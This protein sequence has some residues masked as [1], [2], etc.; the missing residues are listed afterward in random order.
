MGGGGRRPV[1]L[2][3]E[4][5]NEVDKFAGVEGREDFVLAAVQ[6][7]LRRRR[8]AEAIDQAAGSLKDIDIPGWETPESTVEWVRTQR[9][10]DRDHWA[11]AE[12]DANKG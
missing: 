4:I 9:R 5:V 7:Q 2:P 10:L 1:L 6:E 8:L 3:A 11:E 12:A